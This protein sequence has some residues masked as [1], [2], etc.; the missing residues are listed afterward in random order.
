MGRKETCGGKGVPLGGAA[1]QADAQRTL[2]DQEETDHNQGGQLA[3]E[4]LVGQHLP[5]AGPAVVLEDHAPHQVEQH[6]HKEPA[7]HTGGH[8]L[9]PRGKTGNPPSIVRTK[10]TRG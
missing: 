6:P 2:L 5:A 9:R 7:G 10:N 8:Y 1:W 4:L 3:P